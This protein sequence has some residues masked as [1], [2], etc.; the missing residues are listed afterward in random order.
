MADFVLRSDY[1]EVCCFNMT[2]FETLTG[3]AETSADDVRSKLC[4]EG[5]KFTSLLNNR[6]FDAGEFTTPA[7]SHLRQNTVLPANG[8]QN[9]Q[10]GELIADVQSLH[11]DPANDCA[12]FQVASQFNCLEMA[13]PHMTPE[14]GVGVYQNDRTQ[15]PACCICAGG[16]TIYRNYFV[17]HNGKLGQSAESQI[18]C[19]ATVERY[20]DNENNKY[21]LMQNGYCFPSVDGLLEIENQLSQSTESV[22][23]EIRGK[24]MVGVQSDAEI[25]IG[26]LNHSVTQVFCSALPVAYSNIPSKNWNHFPRLILDA[27]YELTFLVALQNLNRTGCNKLYLTLVGGGV[28]GNKLEWILSS[29]SRSLRMF[30]GVPLDVKIVSYGTSKP[31]VAKLAKHYCTA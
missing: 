3:F 23:D 26:D 11:Q 17:D 22:T 2:W 30:S 21:W 13:A 20:F 25:T 27:T 19:L 8:I 10:V 6:T 15:G 4:L 28:F 5:T 18:N 9:L 29:I 12:V 24:L 31:E 16:G 14:D 7:L 1:A